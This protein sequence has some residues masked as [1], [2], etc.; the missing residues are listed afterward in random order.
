L[1]HRHDGILALFEAVRRLRGERQTAR[2]DAG[3]Y[4][5]ILTEANIRALTL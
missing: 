3:Q 1:T 5:R 2:N 4:T